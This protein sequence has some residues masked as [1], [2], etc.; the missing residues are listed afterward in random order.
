MI[1]PYHTAA[2]RSLIGTDLIAT[3]PRSIA[4]LEASNPSMRIVKAPAVLGTFKYLR[5]WHPRL[6]SDAA[7][8]WLRSIIRGAGKAISVDWDWGFI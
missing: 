4:E 6:N 8:V 5:A 2:M 3:A 7:H 1:V